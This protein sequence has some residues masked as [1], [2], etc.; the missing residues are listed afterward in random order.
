MAGGSIDPENPRDRPCSHCGLYYAQQGIFAHERN[1]P[2]KDLAEKGFTII[3]PGGDGSEGI[4]EVEE[5]TPDP[6]AVEGGT[7][8][9]DAVEPTETAAVATDGGEAMDP[10]TFESSTSR[11]SST[12]TTETEV[13]AAAADAVAEVD[14]EPETV[15]CPKCGA[16]SEKRP[17]ELTRGKQYQCSECD[18]RFIYRP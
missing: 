15:D 2:A 11:S 7:P 10:P 17:S 3:P 13:E 4:D 5:P 12:T 1:C 9:P 8:E 6:D 16:D 14:D 18:G